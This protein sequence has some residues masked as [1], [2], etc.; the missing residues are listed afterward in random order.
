MLRGFE[1]LS[2]RKKV[3]MDRIFLQSRL[4]LVN[5]SFFSLPELPEIKWSRGRIK[6]RYR[7]ITFGCYDIKKNEIRIHPLFKTAAFPGFVLDFVIFH[8][9]L[10][11]VDRDILKK[12]RSFFSSS[13][14]RVHNKNFKLRED[15]FPKANEAKILLKRFLNEH[16]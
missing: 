15:E 13:H 14:K 11:Y 5:Q 9:L 3:Y 12:N 7:K 4:E 10:H 8:E 6:K 2:L 1:S 16:I